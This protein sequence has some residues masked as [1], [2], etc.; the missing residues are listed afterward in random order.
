M[1]YLIAEFIQRGGDSFRFNYVYGDV[2]TRTGEEVPEHQVRVAI[3]FHTHA[4][5]MNAQF[6][7]DGTKSFRRMTNATRDDLTR[8]T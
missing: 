4:G 5:A 8:R 1:F 2:R 7:Q 6:T 3:R